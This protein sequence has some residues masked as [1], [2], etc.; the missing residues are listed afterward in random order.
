[1]KNGPSMAA[2]LAAGIGLAV[3]GVVV[4]LSEAIGSVG[5]ALAWVKPVGALSGKSILGV[6]VWLVAWLV[7][8]LIWKDREVR[9][10]PVVVVSA[11]LL[12]IGLLGSFPPFFELFVKG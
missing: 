8:G 6:A 10:G 4:I 3:F 9:H 7:C 5:A 12:V 1:M 11:V 2:V